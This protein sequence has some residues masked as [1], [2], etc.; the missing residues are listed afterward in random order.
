ML[1]LSDLK[2]ISEFQQQSLKPLRHLL[3]RIAGI[4]LKTLYFGSYEEI[5]T[6]YFI[7]TKT[8]KNVI[9]LL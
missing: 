3:T 7:L 1:K 6:A 2:A 4:N 8:V 9:L 5:T